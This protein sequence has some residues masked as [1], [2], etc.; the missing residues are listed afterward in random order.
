[1][2]SYSEITITDI[3]GETTGV[4]ITPEIA[5]M[6]NATV[7]TY[8]DEVERQAKRILERG[9]VLRLR[10]EKDVVQIWRGET[11]ASIRIQ[12]STE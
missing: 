1:M 4:T 11:I 2:P 10:M 5:A 6:E 7:G 9:G 3:H 12:R 8:T